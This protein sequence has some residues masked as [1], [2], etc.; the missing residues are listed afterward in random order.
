MYTF[1][2]V[3]EINSV[4]SINYLLSNTHSLFHSDNSN[5]F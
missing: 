2:E 1:D 5:E 4:T 3:F